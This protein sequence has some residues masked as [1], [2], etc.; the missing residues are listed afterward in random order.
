MNGDELEPAKSRGSKRMRELAP[1]YEADRVKLEK[2]ILSAVGGDPDALTQIAAEALSSAVIGARR[3]RSAG[4]SDAEMLKL[5]AQ[6]T[7]AS[8]LRPS[9]AAAPAPMSM[10][11]MLAARGYTPPVLTSPTSEAVDDEGDQ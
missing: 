8:G 1:I 3:R 6:L 11:D 9:P 7:R 4:K 2:S 5:I 10:A